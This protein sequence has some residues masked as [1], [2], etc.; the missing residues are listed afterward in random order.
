MNSLFDINEYELIDEEKNL[1]PNLNPNLN[2]DSCMLHVINNNLSGFKY[3]GD[4]N[5]CYLYRTSVFDKKIN[6]NIINNYDIK[7]YIKSKNTIDV[8]LKDQYDNTKYF[9]EINNNYFSPSIQINNKEIIV[10]DEIECMDKCRNTHSKCKSIIYLKEPEECIFYK[11]KI[12]KK[13]DFNNMYT[14]YSLKTKKINEINDIKTTYKNINN[15]LDLKIQESNDNPISLYKCNDKFSENPFCSKEYKKSNKD[16][17]KDLHN[18]TECQIIDNSY[19][20]VNEMKNNFNKICKKQF[21]DE[22]VYDTMSDTLECNNNEK[23][24][25]CKFNIMENFDNIYIKPYEC[26]YINIVYLLL[27]LMLIIYTYYIYL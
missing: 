6:E 22:Y 10:N 7:S 20:T 1:N 14:T 23:K 5:K 24:I 3:K 15:I 17:N 18:Y 2:L 12:M 11:N 19:K 21:G 26:K 13:K 8:D 9:S 25:K 27:I 16:S 4:N